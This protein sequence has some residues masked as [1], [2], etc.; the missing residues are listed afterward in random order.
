MTFWIIKSNNI[1][2]VIIAENKESFFLIPKDRGGEKVAN[3]DKK[4]LNLKSQQKFES[5]I[6]KPEDLLFSIQFYTNN[7][8]ENVSKYLKKITNS[9]EIIY[10]LKDFY[11]LALNSE[12]GVDYFL[13]YKNFKERESAKDY[14]LKFLVKLEKCLIVDTTKF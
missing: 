7:D 2:L 6:D 1:D 10:Y 11:I 3:L 14:C 13:L 4:S 9:N 5:A 12:I 8:L